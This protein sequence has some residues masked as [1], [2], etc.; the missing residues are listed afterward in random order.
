MKN[1]IFERIKAEKE[2]IFNILQKIYNSSPGV[3]YQLKLCP[4]GNFCFPFANPAF[5][6]YFNIDP[7]D[8]TEDASKVFNLLHPDDLEGTFISLKQ[9]AKNM[10]HWQHEARI[11][12]A[13]STIRWI[14]G[15]AI[16]QQDQD[17]S[18]IWQGF[19]TDITEQKELEEELNELNKILEQ[20]VM[21][22]IDNHMKQE[23]LLIQQ[24][25][26]AQ[27]GEMIGLIAHQWR[28]PLGILSIIISDFEDIYTLGKMDF[29]YVKDSVD[30]SMQQISFM[31]NTIDDF[32]DFLKPSKEK[33]IFDVQL[34]IEE[35]FSMF[36]KIFIS[37]NIDV[38]II[39]DKGAELFTEGY[40]NEFKQVILNILNNSKDA[41]VSRKNLNFEI[42]RQINISIKNS[43][44]KNKIIVSIS[45][46][47]GGIPA[48]IIQKIFEPYYTTKESSGGTGLG[49]Y[50]S[51][52]I[53][54]TNMG[55]IF[56]ARN[57]TGGAEFLI[58]L[59]VYRG[60][61]KDNDN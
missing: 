55:G 3:I 32:K 42:K 1:E 17:G 31:S 30:K 59:D 14:L 28:Q 15:N 22:E 9:S 43:E 60:G 27:M 56:T 38:S 25:K 18:I 48:A 23:Q 34:N 45:D 26:M 24:S 4:N 51:K 49:L 2:Q 33:I 54:E 53:I 36:K 40:P 46:N 47:G 19:I 16:P 35:L 11:L 57:I 61:I 52:T 44:N 12:Y 6:E 29:K 10:S 37:N 8:V 50:M 13:N 21:E 41:L 5:K 39:T 58:T 7:E 20:R